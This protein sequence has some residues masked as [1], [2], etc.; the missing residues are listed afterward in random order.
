ME[1]SA[2][3]GC[4]VPTAAEQGV[5]VREDGAVLCDDIKQVHTARLYGLGDV[6]VS[7]ERQCTSHVNQP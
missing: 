5:L 3:V 6:V 4:L 7:W 1:Q 2:L